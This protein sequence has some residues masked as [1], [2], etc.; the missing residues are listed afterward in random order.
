MVINGFMKISRLPLD[1]IHKA[2]FLFMLGLLLLDR[3]LILYYFGFRYT[4]IDEMVFWL[5]AN[6][7]SRGVFHEPFFYGQNYNYML[8]ALFAVPFIWAGFPVKFVL[9]AVTSFMALFPYIFISCKLK[10][11]GKFVAALFFLFIPL[12]L[13][14]EYGMITSITR[15]FV[16]GLFF[17]SFL[18]YP[19]LMPEKKSSWVIAGVFSAIAFIMNAN[20]LNVSIPVLAYLFFVN[21]RSW[22]FYLLGIVSALPFL[23]IDWWAKRF[24]EL[25]PEFL[26]HSMWKLSYSF[27]T[28]IKSFN[29]LDRFF[30]WLFPFFPFAGWLTLLVL[31]AIGIYLWK[32]SKEKA[33]SVFTGVAFAVFMLGINKVND[34]YD[35]I[36]LSSVRMYLGMPLFL[37]IS[38]FWFLESFRIREQVVLWLL[39]VVAVCF[40]AFKTITMPHSVEKQTSVG[41]FGP[42]AV[43]SNHEISRKCD[44]LSTLV[45]RHPVD[46]IIFVSNWKYNVSYMTLMS[47]GCPSLN[48]EIPVSVL[49]V[50]ERRT[51]IFLNEKKTVR[52]NVLIFGEFNFEHLKKIANYSRLNDD[53]PVHLIKSNTLT[54]DQLLQE[55]EVQYKRH[56]Y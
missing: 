14:A 40:L 28:M 18:I 32:E 44:W 31:I 29:N 41:N 26:V 42:V 1:K 20:S 24:Y 21:Y 8:E 56:T 49:N 2:A 19:L 7:Y 39:V 33:L 17:T 47:Y 37:A 53:P 15:G 12:S 36:F 10:S 22:N 52:E 9:P 30:S 13:P 46:L 55:L 35:N 48:P 38:V 50:Y 4:D 34:G 43:E 27:S 5:G 25:N 23:V 11:A 45:K 6:D 16:T 54:A 51:W 3:L